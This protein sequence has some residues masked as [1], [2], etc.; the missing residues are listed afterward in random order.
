MRHGLNDNQRV[1]FIEAQS[2]MLNVRSAMMQTANRIAFANG[3]P[4]VYVTED[5]KRVIDQYAK[6]LDAENCLRFLK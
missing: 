5:F 1:A 2:A 6:I 4:P 3:N